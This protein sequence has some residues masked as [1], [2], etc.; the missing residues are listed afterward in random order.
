GFGLLWLLSTPLGA[1]L[2]LRPLETPYLHPALP[3]QADV[4]VT[5]G[6]TL[7]L[8]LS[9][10]GRLEYQDAA[11]RFIYTLKLARRLPKA[12]V[13]F[14]G[15]TADLFNQGRT[16]AS[17]LKGE[18]VELGLAPGRIFVD[19][20]SRNTHENAVETKRVL[21]QVHGTRLVLITSAFHMKRSLACLRK[22]GL[23]ATPYAVDVRGQRVRLDPRALLPSVNCLADSSSAVREYIGLLLYRLQG[24]L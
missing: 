2:L 3:K 23:T 9:E 18:A 22:V 12:V 14:T 13:I 16:E 8:G 1:Y 5:L 4:I 15:G 10:P 20:K 7:N 24:Y 17:L 11:D 6:G 19:D 21:A